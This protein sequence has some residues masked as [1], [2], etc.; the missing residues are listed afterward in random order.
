MTTLRKQV[1]RQGFTLIELLV[2]IAIIG[3]LAAVLLP[4]LA[5]A[6]EAAR[7]S[8]CA[9]N[10][11]QWGLVFKMYSGESRGETFPRILNQYYARDAGC[12]YRPGRVRGFVWMPSI[13]PEYLTDLNLTTCPSD[14][15]LAEMQDKWNCPGGSWCQ[16][17]CVSSPIFGQL[18]PAKIGNAEDVS[19]YYYGYVLDSDGAFATLNATLRGSLEAALPQV[20]G[21]LPGIAASGAAAERFLAG[22]YNPFAQ[23]DANALQGAFESLL[24]NNGVTQTLMPTGTGGG[25][26]MRRMR[27]GI[28]RFLITDI[29]NP[30]AS[31]KAQSDIAAMWDRIYFRIGDDRRNVR[32]NHIPGG[33][34]VV[35][36]DGHVEFLRYPQDQFP[37]TPVHAVFGRF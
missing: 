32:F 3:I 30:A 22:D 28:E 20:Q 37:I 26:S 36:M 17:D 27:E 25:T 23:F 21:P 4:A 16:N 19:Y 9:N 15:D 2:V 35:Y 33:S 6:R 14:Y 31:A 10:L 18:D 12:N 5:R 13:F 11:K 1:G 7:R 29:N 24:A 34:N 8:S